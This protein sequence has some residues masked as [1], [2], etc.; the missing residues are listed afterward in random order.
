MTY[1]RWE[2]TER[3]RNCCFLVELTITDY[4]YVYQRLCS[5]LV[6]ACAHAFS[7]CFVQCHRFYSAMILVSLI[8]AYGRRF[9]L[10]FWSSI[11]IIRR[12]VLRM[13]TERFCYCCCYCCCC[14]YS[15]IDRKSWFSKKALHLAKL[16]GSNAM[17]IFTRKIL[18]KEKQ[19]RQEPQ[20]PRNI[21]EMIDNQ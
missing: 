17:T 9:H 15:W 2:S 19:Q 14:C 1:T 8:A 11:A 10:M 13:R 4:V 18:M 7:T 5:F 3:W 16:K 20:H 6:C 21:R 12:E